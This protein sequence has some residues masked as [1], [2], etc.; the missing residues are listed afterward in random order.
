MSYVKGRSLRPFGRLWWDET[1]P[2]VLTRAKPHNQKILHPGQDRVL[3]VRENARLQG[4]PDYYRMWGSIKQKYMQV[5]NA[6]AVPVARALGYSLG[7]A[8]Q[9]RS[10]GS[11]PSL[12]VLPKSFTSLGQSEVPA[13]EVVE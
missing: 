5:G 8:L 3:S 4:F 1:V 12:F 10:E 13:G 7:Q 11:D 9:G 2:T 6:V